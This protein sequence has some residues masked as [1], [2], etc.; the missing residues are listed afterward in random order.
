MTAHFDQFN[1]SED[2]RGAPVTTL[3]GKTGKKRSI[4]VVLQPLPE[5]PDMAQRLAQIYALALERYH[6]HQNST[7]VENFSDLSTSGT[8]DESERK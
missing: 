7:R 1:T 8:D 6:E 2:K 4:R 5:P 3:Y